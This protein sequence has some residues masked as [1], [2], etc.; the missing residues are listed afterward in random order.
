MNA[1][2]NAA[3]KSTAPALEPLVPGHS[4]NDRLVVIVD[5]ARAG[6]YE[7]PEP[8]VAAVA[9]YNRAHRLADSSVRRQR[10]ASL[11]LRQPASGADPVADM[12]KRKAELEQAMTAREVHAAEAV[13]ASAALGRLLSEQV[14]V[15]A[16]AAALDEVLAEVRRLPSGAPTTAESA[17]EASEAGRAAYRRLVQLQARHEAIRAAQSACR[18]DGVKATWRGGLFFDTQVGPDLGGRA[19]VIGTPVAKAGPSD[20]VAR[21]VW[22]AGEGRG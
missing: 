13:R 3:T 4:V 19:I 17:V 8:A 7:L 22:L 12:A 16:L 11:R 10:E 20:P 21:L 15:P 14:V 18:G 2:A 6:H 5:G 1:A 9:A